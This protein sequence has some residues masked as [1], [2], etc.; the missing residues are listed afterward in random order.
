MSDIS[1]RLLGPR[2]VRPVAEYA[3]WPAYFTIARAF[4]Q[5]A[6]FLV[7]VSLILTADLIDSPTRSR[8]LARD[9]I[10][11]IMTAALGIA[12]ADQL[13]LIAGAVI[14]ALAT[15]RLYLTS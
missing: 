12:I 3:L 13:G 2:V 14:A 9:L 4:N 5:E 1:L 6:F 15:V 11:G 10:A 7:A 8:A